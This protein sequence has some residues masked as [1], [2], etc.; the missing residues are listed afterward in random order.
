MSGIGRLDRLDGVA[1]IDRALEGICRD[2]F[3]NLGYL[4][5]LIWSRKSAKAG[6]NHGR[7][8]HGNRWFEGRNRTID[9]TLQLTRYP[10]LDDRI[11]ILC[12]ADEVDAGRLGKRHLR[13]INART[14]DHC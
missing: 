6:T 11:T 1:G 2:D 5:Q 7:K 10:G 12:A 8:G 9:L 3:D 13:V 4:R 14:H